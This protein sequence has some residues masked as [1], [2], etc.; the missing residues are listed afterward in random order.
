MTGAGT[1]RNVL[2]PDEGDICVVYGIGGVGFG[3]LMM[4]KALGCST[5]IAVDLNED[6]LALARE[7]GATHTINGAAP[8]LGEQITELTKANSG[9]DIAVDTTGLATISKTAVSTL[10]RGGRLGLLGFYNQNGEGMDVAAIPLG[11]YVYGV[12]EGDSVPPAEMVPLL[13]DLHRQGKFPFDRLITFYELADINQAF[14]DSH[15]GTAI[16]PVIRFPRS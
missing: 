13:V 4:A 12:V 15:A 1:V 16:K 10:R 7:L 5:I 2:K 3:A 6:R 11:S 9:V 14:A 8:D